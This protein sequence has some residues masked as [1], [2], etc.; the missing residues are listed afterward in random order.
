MCPTPNVAYFRQVATLHGRQRDGC[1][2]AGGV[3]GVR[4]GWFRAGST[5]PEHTS[6]KSVLYHVHILTSFFANFCQV[7]TLHGVGML[8]APL[9]VV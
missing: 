2:G 7:A 3:G 4:A 8:L 1:G 9:G 6:K 5:E